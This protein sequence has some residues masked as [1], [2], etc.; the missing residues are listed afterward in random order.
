MVYHVVESGERRWLIKAVS[1]MAGE[2]YQQFAGVDEIGLRYRPLARDWCLKE[3]AGHLR[4]AEHLYQRQIDLIAHGRGDP[5]PFEP[6]DLLPEERDYRDEPLRR[7]LQDYSDMREETVWL[8]YSL[9]EE[10]WSMTGSHPYRGEVS[11]YDI[12]RELHEHDLDHLVQA[13]RLRD[14]V[15]RR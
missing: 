4:D 2:L 8:L 3:L 5:L 6:I 12:A 15:N 13:R 10:Q 14:A 1:E 11:I 7:F 9:E